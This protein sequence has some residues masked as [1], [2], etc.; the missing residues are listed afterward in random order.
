MTDEGEELPEGGGRCRN[1]DH[2]KAHFGGS[3]GVTA[4][5]QV[6]REEEKT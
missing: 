4:R 2:G 5:A 6:P 3:L 1:G